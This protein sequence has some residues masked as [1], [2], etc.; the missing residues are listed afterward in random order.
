M[1][2]EELLGSLL[3]AFGAAAYVLLDPPSA[4]LAAQEYRAYVA[5]PAV[6]LDYAGREEVR[7]I[8]RGL[9]FL[10]RCRRG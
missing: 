9:A 2:R 5:L 4:D 3:A 6:A 8:G 7:L 1:R 10:R